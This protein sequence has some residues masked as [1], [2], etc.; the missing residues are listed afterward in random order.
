MWAVSTPVIQFCFLSYLGLGRATVQ[1]HMRRAELL[2]FLQ[3]KEQYVHCAAEIGDD[4]K[5]PGSEAQK[6]ENAYRTEDSF[7]PHKDKEGGWEGIS[8]RKVQVYVT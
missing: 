1:K 6:R 7:I 8:N 5:A 3:G 4:R 2:L